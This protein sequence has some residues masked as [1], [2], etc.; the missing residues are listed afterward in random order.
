MRSCWAQAHDGLTWEEDAHC[1]SF[2]T[3]PRCSTPKAVT[4]QHLVEVKDF[5]ICSCFTQQI[6]FPAQHRSAPSSWLGKKAGKKYLSLARLPSNPSKAGLDVKHHWTSQRT[7]LAFAVPG[8]VVP[9]QYW[10]NQLKQQT[11]ALKS[12]MCCFLLTWTQH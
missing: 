7:P 10:M 2:V 6:P 8:H 4:S 5:Q 3:W 1:Y 9:W 11:R 12:K